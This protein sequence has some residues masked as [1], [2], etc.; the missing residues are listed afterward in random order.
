[1]SFSRLL[2][3]SSF[4]PLPVSV[5]LI[6]ALRA[7]WNVAVAVATTTSTGFLARASWPPFGPIYHVITRWPALGAVN[8]M[9]SPPCFRRWTIFAAWRD[10]ASAFTSVA[11]TWPLVG[12]ATA[13]GPTLLD[14][15]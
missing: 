2:R 13:T 3:F 5:I 7:R 14:V 11:F 12:P 15:A 4:W 10:T 6:L 8:V 1:M 9:T